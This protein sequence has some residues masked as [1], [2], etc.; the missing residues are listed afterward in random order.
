[1]SP[2]SGNAANAVEL[3]NGNVLVSTDAARIAE[4]TPTGTLV[5]DTSLTSEFTQITQMWGNS[6]GDYWI[7]GS[8][9]NPARGK[10]Y[11]SVNGAVSTKRLGGF[12]NIHDIVQVNS[13][14]YLAA[15]L[16]SNSYPYLVKL[17][18]Q[19]DS[20]WSK[21][22]YINSWNKAT[23][24]KYYDGELLLAG[25]W[26]DYPAIWNYDTLGNQNWR[27]DSAQF[28]SLNYAQ[29]YKTASGYTYIG[30]NLLI[31]L[32]MNGNYVSQ[33]HYPKNDFYGIIYQYQTT[34][35]H[36][37]NRDTSNN[38]QP[39]IAAVDANYNI[40]DSVYYIFRPTTNHQ[41]SF[42]GG[43]H[44][45]NDD[46][47]VNGYHSDDAST[48]HN[49][50][51]YLKGTVNSIVENRMDPNLEVYPNPV[52][53]M[54]TVESDNGIEVLEIVDLSGRRMFLKRY[55]KTHRTELDLSHLS[56]GV[57]IVRITDFEGN[58]DQ[59]KVLKN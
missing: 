28:I 21:D 37:S 5:K 16:V 42:W 13:N 51:A 30:R 46:V 3:A 22:L 11:Q 49:I 14:F 59:I 57:Y 44:L 35:M 48:K 24:I 45:S 52:Q 38:V 58:R 39:L 12:F 33:V 10:I 20:V 47:F 6:A 15:E 55:Q 9:G 31:N 18:A 41:S 32:D 1:M 43:L 53:R 19:L 26:D 17:D 36:G 40:I 4:Y 34:L 27:Y 50:M 23:D 56:G 8:G 25:F 2:I 54:L 7:V 29:A